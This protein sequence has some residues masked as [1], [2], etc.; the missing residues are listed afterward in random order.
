MSRR[1]A[2]GLAIVILISLA[3]VNIALS[4]SAL[5]Q[6]SPDSPYCVLV[7]YPGAQYGQVKAIIQKGTERYTYDIR[8]NDDP[9]SLP[10]QMGE[11]TYTVRLMRNTRANLYSEITRKTITVETVDEQ[12]LY[13][14]SIQNIAW[15]DSETLKTLTEETT[16]SCE[17]DADKVQS[18]Y[19]YIADNIAY[20]YEKARTVA[21]GY[22]PDLDQVLLDEKGICYDFAS[23]FAGMLRSIGVPTKLVTGYVGPRRAYHAWNE[24]YDGSEWQRYDITRDIMG[25]KKVP[26]TPSQTTYETRYV[27]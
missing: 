14:A 19:R 1:V 9:E 5:I 10:L 25:G 18:V 23:L 12:E 15:A 4:G 21:A 20:D 3:P 2:L 24:V 17:T 22:F 8:P 7:G 6:Q 16:E 26:G 27:Y 13:L 11:G